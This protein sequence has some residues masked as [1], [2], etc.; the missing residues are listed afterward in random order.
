MS[1]YELEVIP[2]H[3]EEM[4]QIA[5]TTFGITANTGMGNDASLLSSDCKHVYFS[6]FKKEFLNGSGHY[7]GE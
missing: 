7:L 6:L 5:A 2:F 1:C 4:S 3:N